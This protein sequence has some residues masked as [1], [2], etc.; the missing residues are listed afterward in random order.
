MKE[1]IH[2]S[3]RQNI[4][5]FGNRFLM[6]SHFKLMFE[7]ML[8]NSQP[9]SILPEARS[10]GPKMIHLISEIPSYSSLVREPLFLPLRQNY[11]LKKN[12]C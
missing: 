4:A 1:P 9:I 7:E 11:P 10:Q 2:D 3:G 5:H 6:K 12:N 8:I